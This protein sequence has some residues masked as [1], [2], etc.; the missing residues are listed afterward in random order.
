MSSS[1]FD[2]KDLFVHCEYPFS[3]CSLLFISN[4]G[5]VDFININPFLSNFIKEKTT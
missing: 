1:F 4:V 3:L 5:D 2:W